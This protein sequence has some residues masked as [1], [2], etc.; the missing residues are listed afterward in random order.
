MAFRKLNVPIRFEKVGKKKIQVWFDNFEYYQPNDHVCGDCA[1]RAV[2]K[3]IGSTWRDALSKMYHAALEIQDTPTSRDVIGHVL[4]EYG[5]EW[6][7]IKPKRGEKR[8][9]VAVFAAE[10]NGAYVLDIAGHVVCA[11]NGKY[12]DIWDCG[13]KSMYGYWQKCGS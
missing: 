10:N 13:N 12:Y 8:P 1:I 9:T 4:K 7:P 6:V 5:F 11:S 3:A 2:S